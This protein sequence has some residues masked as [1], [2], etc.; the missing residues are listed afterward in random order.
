MSDDLSEETLSADYRALLARMADTTD[1]RFLDALQGTAS[2]LTVADHVAGCARRGDMIPI[3]DIAEA[4]SLRQMLG[5][6]R[7]AQREDFDARYVT[8][9]ADAREISDYLAGEEIAIMG[10]VS[11]VMQEIADAMLEEHYHFV[12]EP[13]PRVVAVEGNVIHVR[14][15]D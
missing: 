7:R 13:T 9:Y 15:G 4:Q 10:G 14:F 11:P 3:H 5:D 12:G 8:S 6:A 2:I 1:T